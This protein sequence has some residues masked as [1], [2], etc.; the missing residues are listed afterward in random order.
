MEG[1]RQKQ[2]VCVKNVI[3]THVLLGTHFFGIEK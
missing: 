2:S 1:E 3:L